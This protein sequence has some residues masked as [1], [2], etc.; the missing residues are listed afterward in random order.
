MKFN[1]DDNND[2]DDDYVDSVQVFFLYISVFFLFE[3]KRNEKKREVTMKN[4]GAVA[5]T[6]RNEKHI[7]IINIETSTLKEL[8]PC[9]EPK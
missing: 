2:D 9:T 3:I 1:T 7:I 6:T 5:K 8:K 4:K